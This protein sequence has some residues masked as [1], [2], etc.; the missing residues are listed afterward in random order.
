MPATRREPPLV[1]IP[2]LNVQF[3]QKT[4]LAYLKHHR[5]PGHAIHNGT[6][7]D[8][9]DRIASRSQFRPRESF[10]QEPAPRVHVVQLVVT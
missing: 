8:T 1:T 10:Q 2:Q 6:A 9:P 5:T 7:W 4:F 3:A